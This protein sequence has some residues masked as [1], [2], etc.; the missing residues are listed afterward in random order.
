MTTSRLVRVLATVCLLGGVSLTACGD[1]TAPVGA[2]ISGPSDATINVS[3][4]DV[5]PA[6]TL[7]FGVTDASGNAV[8]GVDIEFFAASS[9]TGGSAAALTDADGNLLDPSNP[10]NAVIQTD[11]RGLGRV[12]FV[13][14][15]STTCDPVTPADLT[16]TGIVS[17]SVGVASAQWTGTYNVKCT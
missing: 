8:P 10:T 12:R 14:G 6:F 15:F 16:A 4:G 2:T 5:P 17:A 3:P 9:A 13:I 1:E 11:D 7:T